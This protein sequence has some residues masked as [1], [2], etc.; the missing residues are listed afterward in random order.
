MAKSPSALTSPSL[1]STSTFD[2]SNGGPITPDASGPRLVQKQVVRVKGT[3]S[4]ALIVLYLKLAVPRTSNTQTV[5]L[6]PD[7]GVILKSSQVYSVN[8]VKGKTL[9]PPDA[10]RSLQ[11]ASEIL[12]ISRTNAFA[13]SVGDETSLSSTEKTFRS[14]AKRAK[15]TTSNFQVSFVVPP[16]TDQST[17][18]VVDDKAHFVAII[19]LSISYASKPPKWPYVVSLVDCGMDLLLTQFDSV[20][21]RCIYLFPAA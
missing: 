15:I 6:F 21:C 7:D 1:G 3:A 5:E 11:R 4:E 18:K 19:H 8:V 17:S 10:S 9:I 20:P 12:S 13:S 16:D 2:W 14:A